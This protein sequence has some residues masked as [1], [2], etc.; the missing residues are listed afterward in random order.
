M[1]HEQLKLKVYIKLLE[2]IYE[3]DGNILVTQYI[4]GGKIGICMAVSDSHGE[5]ELAIID[6]Y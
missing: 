3:K 2:D 6:D 1:G 5:M 4:Q